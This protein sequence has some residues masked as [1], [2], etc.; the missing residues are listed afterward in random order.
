MPSLS[1]L[2]CVVQLGLAAAQTAITVNVGSTLQ[3][4][5]GFGVSQAFGR[6]KEFQNLAAGP[7]KQGLDYLFNTSTGAGLTIIRNRIGSGGSGDSI[8]PTSPG[9][10]GGTPAYSWD[11][12]DSG[13]VWF[14]RQ[15]ASYGVQTIY[16]DAWSAP[17]FM[18]TNG[19]Q[20][21]GGY[22]CGTTGHSCASGDWRAAY[23]DLLVQYV[24]YYA[25]AGI[26]VTHLG[27]LNEPDY[28][29]GYSSMLINV[30][31]A[32]EAT[33]FIPTLHDALQAAGLGDI[34]MTCCDAMGWPNALKIGSALVSAGME[35]YLSVM[36]SHMY[37]G[38]PNS[39]MNT[40]LTVWQ[41]EA[42]DLNSQWCTTWYSSGG[43][44]E[45]MTWAGK[46][47]TGILSANL[48]AYIYWQGTEINQGQA[49]SYLVA[50]LDGET[51][52]PS[53][54]LWAFAMWSRFIRPGAVRLATSGSISSVAIGA[55]RNTDGSVVAVFT[56]SGGSAQSAMISFSGDFAPAVAE[57]WL[58]DN[59]HSVASTG[60]TLSGGAVTVSLPAHSVVTVRL[61]SG[62]SGG[63][64]GGSSSSAAGA[65]STLSTVTTTSIIGTTSVIDIVTTTTAST[66]GCAAA[67]WAQC[68]GIG[69][70][71]CT[72][73]ASGYTCKSLND[74]YS[75]C[76]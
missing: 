9:S 20:S 55:F 6:A 14:S 44:C 5:D 18:K 64:S 31:N 12:D 39:V 17:G 61:T 57:A 29:V 22:L 53:G 34:K 76:L 7:Q 32:Q 3:H 66:G 71:G 43:L 63:S 10:P 73:C 47:A 21:N 75:Q 54:R 65:P 24:R 60:A 23:A 16:A 1:K 48:S 11:G 35:K 50:V 26:N 30:N 58:T 38:D 28:S 51:A 72:N 59:S 8:L 27:F 68:G 42:A 4:I 70:S 49:S 15:A 45:G 13:Q 52:T 37:S 41:T 69:Y 33:S 40:K 56:N 74:Y 25:Q 62:D 36:T 46:I 67:Q 2:L 19:D